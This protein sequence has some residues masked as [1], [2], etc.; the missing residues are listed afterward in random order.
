M[1]DHLEGLAPPP[2]TSV[3]IP[4]KD[5]VEELGRA[6]DSVLTQSDHDLEIVVVDDGSVE[7][8]EPRVAP[9]H[10]DPRLRFLRQENAGP[11]QARNSGVRAA[12]GGYVA[13]LDSDDTWAP[14][15]LVLQIERFRARP[16]LALVGTGVRFVR[17]DGSAAD[18][19]RTPK[20]GTSRVWELLLMVT[21]SVMV[22]RSVF[23]AAGGFSRDLFFMEDK[24][25][26]LR[27]GLTHDFE[28]V[29]A[30]LTIV[31]MNPTSTTQRAWKDLGLVERYERDIRTFTR[32]VGP[33][34]RPT[35]WRHLARKVSIL[36]SDLAEMFANHGRQGRALRSLVLATLLSP[37]DPERYRRLA[38]WV[39]TRDGR[40]ED[41]QAP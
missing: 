40:S 31:H 36:E 25:L 21:P 1:N 28:T 13:F 24:E 3:V 14:E 15:K 6:I 2:R 27:I 16:E 32:R 17:D 37:V 23:L 4:A 5:R 41:R 19:T 34:M 39:R 9:S 38:R 10:R 12:R 18:E 7:P 26:F 11:A 35:E 30:P 8:L 20:A 33:L 22:R 29:A